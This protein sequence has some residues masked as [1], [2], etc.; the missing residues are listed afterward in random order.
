MEWSE[1]DDIVVR[2]LFRGRPWHIFA[3]RVVHDAD[4]VLALWRPAGAAWLAPVGDRF[5]EW[6]HEASRLANPDLRLTP[7]GASHS[8]LVLWNETG[9]FK[10][11]YVNLEDPL[12]RTS[13]GY[14]Y[15]DH[16]LD[17]WIEPDGKWEWLDEDEFGEAIERGFMTAQKAGEVR[18][19][20]ERVMEAW[21]FPTGWED[22][23]PD[24]VWPAPVLPADWNLP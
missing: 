13:H 9:G 3:G 8:I 24:P 15:E 17:I 18:S 10:A 22:W 14:D 23:Q 19:E 12:R 21:P 7:T 16:L 2:H 1:G 4:D 5:G 11:W 6:K 20:R